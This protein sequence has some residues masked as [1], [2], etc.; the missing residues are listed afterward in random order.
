[1]KKNGRKAKRVLAASLLIFFGITSVLSATIAGIT[2]TYK[3]DF[4]STRTGIFNFKDTTY[5][6]DVFPSEEIFP[7]DSGRGVFVFPNFEGR[8]P[9]WTMT[10]QNEGCIPI[11]FSIEEAYYSAYSFAEGYYIADADGKYVACADI[12]E[13]KGI[14][15]AEVKDGAE[16]KWIWPSCL[17]EKSGEEYKES[18]SAE[19]VAYKEYN[20]EFCESEYAFGAGLAEEL[21]SVTVNDIAHKP[22][23]YISADADSATQSV[24][25]AKNGISVMN[26]LYYADGVAVTLMQ[27]GKAV[28][29]TADT[30]L[31]K[32]DYYAFVIRDN[33]PLTAEAYMGKISEEYNG[34]LSL[35]EKKY[36]ITDSAP[37]ELTEENQRFRILKVYASPASVKRG[38]ISVTFSAT[39][40]SDR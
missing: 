20:E 13:D 18:A 27:N 34:V 16:I 9:I 21:Y 40:S 37:Y 30:V 28:T 2:A 7:G 33:S 14:L 25:E 36:G 39:I 6:M 22:F 3:W 38:T 35:S 19:A 23:G 32:D 12:T 31:T 29:P 4:G 26:G 5:D 24:V 8:T 15:L 1:M 11:M 10:E 17:Y